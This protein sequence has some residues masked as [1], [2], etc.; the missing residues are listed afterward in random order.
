[1]NDVYQCLLQ[2]V[3]DPASHVTNQ[4]SQLQ[5]H[6]TSQLLADK[7]QP[8]DMEKLVAEYLHASGRNVR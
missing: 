1:M 2:A 3:L 7:K 5:S 8:R 6:V 4:P